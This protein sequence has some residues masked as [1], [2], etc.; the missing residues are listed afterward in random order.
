MKTKH[1]VLAVI[2]VMIFTLLGITKV[3][4]EN[5]PSNLYAFV[6]LDNM[7]EFHSIYSE[8]QI[9]NDEVEGVS[10][11]LETNTVTLNNVNAPK[12]VLSANKMGDDF[13]VKLVGENNL[14]IICIYGD[15]YGGSLTITGD[16]VLNIDTSNFGL[17]PNEAEEVNG[18]VLY[19]ENDNAKLTIENTATVNIKAQSNAIKIIDTPNSNKN[20]AII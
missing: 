16:G 17:I 2:A 5:G 9:Y 12:L 4:A 19:A 3:S 6:Q 14:A 13:K 11:D 18:I 1:I 20:N 7:E 10:Y 8:Q 15:N